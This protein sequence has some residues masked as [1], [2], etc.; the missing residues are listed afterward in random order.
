MNTYTFSVRID[1]ARYPDFDVSK[2]GSF[3]LRATGNKTPYDLCDIL[4]DHLPIDPPT[5][6]IYEPDSDNRPLDSFRLKVGD[7]LRLSGSPDWL[8][9]VTAI[10][11]STTDEDGIEL[12]LDGFDVELAA[13]IAAEDLCH[14]VDDALTNPVYRVVMQGQLYLAFLNHCMKLNLRYRTTTGSPLL[15][16]LVALIKQ[17]AHGL[18]AKKDGRLL[19]DGTVY[20]CAKFRDWSQTSIH[21]AASPTVIA[22]LP[23][24]ED[25]QAV[26]AYFSLGGLPNN[27]LV[28][29]LVLNNG[30]YWQWRDAC[31]GKIP[32]S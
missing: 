1:S 19:V 16:E 30:D 23:G 14:G 9:V 13:E 3:V 15:G 32:I 29:V 7:E 20:D 6:A 31:G 26:Q 10:E 18:V 21:D 27:D 17:Q 11:P 5:P 24:G 12:D 22:T 4:P 28:S 8:L 2:A 25:V